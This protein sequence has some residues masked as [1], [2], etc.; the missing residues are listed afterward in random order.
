MAAIF[1][2][3][4]GKPSLLQRDIVSVEMELYSSTYD[5]PRSVILEIS[6]NEIELSLWSWAQ[7]KS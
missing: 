7:N 6:L 3:S 2:D 4:E 5:D 1:K